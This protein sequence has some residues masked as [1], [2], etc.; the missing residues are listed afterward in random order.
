MGAHDLLAALGIVAGLLG[1]IVVVL[2]GIVIVVGSVVVWA[3]F[4]SSTAGWV[5]MA[6]A[7]AVGLGTMSLKY[8]F[9]GRKL[10]RAGIPTS[11]LVIALGVAVVGFFVIPVIGAFVGFVVAV[12][13]LQRRRVGHD[14]ARTATVA[15]LRAIAMSIG[16]ELVGGFAVAAV[17]LVAAIWG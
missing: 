1:T 13:A 11:H 8:L 9:P 2:P 14:R 6:L 12:Y 5:A 17:W 7:L 16:I 15:A 10:K 4:E 3:L